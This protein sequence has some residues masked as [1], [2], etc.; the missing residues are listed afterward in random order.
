MTL[1]SNGTG[2]VTKQEDAPAP[3]Q[4]ANG[5]APVAEAKP[6]DTLGTGEVKDDGASAA[7]KWP[8]KWREMLA[9][10]DEKMLNALKVIG[11]PTDLGKSWRSAQVMISSGELKKANKLT[12]DATPEQV[13]AWRKENGIPETPDKY[14]LSGVEIA[15]EHKGIV[16]E[17]TK[18][19][20]AANATPEQVK[21]GLKAYYDMVGQQETVLAENNQKALQ[22]VEEALRAEYGGEYRTNIN[23][24][25]GMIQALPDNIGQRLLEATMPDG[26]KFV[27]SPQ[28]MQWLVGMARQSN[29]VGAL[30]PAAGVATLADAEKE[31]ASY[32]QKMGDRFSDYWSGPTAAQQQQR[33]R[34][35]NALIQKSKKVA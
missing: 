9:G 30:L 23:L 5:A 16:G 14:D 17:W 35:L 8:D 13:A 29:P 25:K 11:S 21:A 27:N 26:V 24:F 4:Q 6:A 10:N 1:E 34:E 2:E 18:A 15:E 7:G 12:A 31:L 22:E 19:M 3:E 32:K 33:V 20:H 28:V